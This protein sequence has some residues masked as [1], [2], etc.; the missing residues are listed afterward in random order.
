MGVRQLIE[1]ISLRC[2]YQARP[3]PDSLEAILIKLTCLLE[4]V[5]GEILLRLRDSQA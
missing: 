5:V 4:K 3:D 1:F 2:Q